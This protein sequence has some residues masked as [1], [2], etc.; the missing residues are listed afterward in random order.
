MKEFVEIE[1]RFGRM[2]QKIN[3]QKRELRRLNRILG[4]YH[5]S[6][7]VARV[8]DAEER[9][10]ARWVKAQ[11]EYS[12]RAFNKEIAVEQVKRMVAAD[13]ISFAFGRMIEL[14]QD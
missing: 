6:L 1:Q 12:E 7:R 13:Q 2:Q 3:N 8:Q 5:D 14:N 11:K 10:L 9:D 4:G